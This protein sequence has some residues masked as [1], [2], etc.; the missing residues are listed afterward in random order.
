MKHLLII[1]LLLVSAIQAQAQKK[2]AKFISIAVTN[3]QTV[4]PFGKFSSLLYKDLHPGVEAG[5][6][7]NWKTKQKHDWFQE[8]KAGYF[9]LRF[10][11]HGIQVYTNIGY[12][13]KFSSALSAEMVLG[14]GYLHSIPATAKLK[15]DENGE[16]QNNKGIGRVQAVVNC[17]LRVSYAIHAS[18]KKSIR[19]FVQY[20][21][22]LQMPF[23]KSYVPLLPY[24]SFQVG[25]RRS[26]KSK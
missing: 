10:V 3:T 23:V 7:F 17:G 24:N 19:L 6:D 16:Y 25:V 22:H 9:F 8:F 15:L 20:Q 13:Y 4:M 11:Q 1:C 12:R 2:K 14:G 21:Q 26:L 5:L 18:T